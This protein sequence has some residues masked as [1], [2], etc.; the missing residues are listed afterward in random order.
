MVYMPAT[1]VRKPIVVVLA[2]S[3]S[4]LTMRE[5]TEKLENEFN[6]RLPRSSLSRLLKDLTRGG[7]INWKATD[8]K[9][10]AARR[11]R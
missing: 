8:G 11:E 4:G 5:I 9:F 3:P 7:Q 1:S 6:I 10:T 2:E